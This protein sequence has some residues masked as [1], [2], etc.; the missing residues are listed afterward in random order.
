MS[1]VEAQRAA[2]TAAPISFAP[3][4]Y[5]EGDDGKWSTFVVRVG[6]PEQ[7]FRVLPS[8]VSSETLLPMA[9][10]CKDDEHMSTVSLVPVTYETS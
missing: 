8:T 4:Q 7:S 9:G 10:A 2:A 3:S 6:T 5:F 1:S